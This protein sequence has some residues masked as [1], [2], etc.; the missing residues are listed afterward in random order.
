MQEHLMQTK[1][2]TS[3]GRALLLLTATVFLFALAPTA[4]RAGGPEDSIDCQPPPTSD[5]PCQSSSNGAGVGGSGGVLDD[6]WHVL[7]YQRYVYTASDIKYDLAY[8]ARDEGTG[9][10]ELEVHGALV[11]DYGGAYTNVYT[12]DPVYG[13]NELAAGGTTDSWHDIDGVTWLIAS[14]HYYDDGDNG[15]IDASCNGCIDQ[16]HN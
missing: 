9:P 6:Y 5:Q 15:T 13:Y 10:H 4:A 3:V 11:K 14:G 2:R 8:S 12:F 7:W 16:F 1:L